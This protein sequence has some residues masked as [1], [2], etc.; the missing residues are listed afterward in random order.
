M[1]KVHGLR[2]AE[3]GTV[4]EI[5]LKSLEGYQAAVGGLIECVPFFGGDMYVNEEGLL[6]GLSHNFRA[7]CLVGFL[8]VGPAIVLGPCDKKGN[9]T[10]ILPEWR[11]AILRG[12][13]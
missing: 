4:T 7:S 8:I 12:K 10:S 9:N 13:A 11:E 3:D 5:T 6:L 1:T 2:I